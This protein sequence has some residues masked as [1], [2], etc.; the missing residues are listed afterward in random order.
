MKSISIEIYF[1]FNDLFCNQ[2]H[3]GKIK[4]VLSTTIKPFVWSVE[5]ILRRIVTEI[6]R[7]QSLLTSNIY[8][9]SIFFLT[10]TPCSDLVTRGTCPCQLICWGTCSCWKLISRG[11]FPCLLI[12]T[13]TSSCQELISRVKLVLASWSVVELVLAESWS[14]G[15]LILL[16][17]WSMIS[18]GTCPC[19]R[20]DAGR[21]TREDPRMF[22]CKVFI[23]I[24]NKQF[25]ILYML[26]N[27]YSIN[28]R[29]SHRIG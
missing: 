13:G 12:S 4:R 23:N 9:H 24:Y 2:R 21:C 8:Q 17:S 20:G 18:R 15:E 27:S 29:L 16:E 14:V 19:H 26:H 3:H 6:H 5:Q 7:I 11:T 25:I 28:H 10:N 1:F 22:F